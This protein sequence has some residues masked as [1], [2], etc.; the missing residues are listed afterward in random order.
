MQE[1]IEVQSIKKEK[2]EALM[3]NAKCI[4][5]NS[6]AFSNTEFK[7]CRKKSWQAQHHRVRPSPAVVTSDSVGA[8]S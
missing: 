7:F 6:V 4:A 8:Y 1:I 2:T 5:V 3:L